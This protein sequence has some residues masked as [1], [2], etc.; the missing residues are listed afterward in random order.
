MNLKSR[1][2]NF[3][4]VNNEANEEKFLQEDLNY[5]KE[6][7]ILLEAEIDL[8]QRKYEKIIA[9]K[10]NEQKE[11]EQKLVQKSERLSK[12]FEETE[13]YISMI[14]N[15]E[16]ELKK[17]NEELMVH[18]QEEKKVDENK[19]KKGEEKKEEK[20]RAEGS[21]KEKGRA[22]DE[23]T[24]EKMPTKGEKQNTRKQSKF[25]PVKPVKTGVQLIT[26]ML[27]N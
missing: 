23:K 2:K 9:A 14:K 20:G 6:K 27:K 19:E 7:R 8:V 15:I 24:D 4:L 18:S 13:T 1:I 16:S 21:K 17:M 26:G 3:D 10:Q 11:T 5:Y 12:F 22:E 25:S